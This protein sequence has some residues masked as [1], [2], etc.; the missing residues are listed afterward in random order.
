MGRKVESFL[1]GRF[2]RGGLIDYSGK[3]LSRIKTKMASID[4]SSSTKQHLSPWCDRH[5]PLILLDNV[6]EYDHYSTRE[7]RQPTPNTA[8]QHR[9]Q[10]QATIWP[11][12]Q[13]PRAPPPRKA[14]HLPLSDQT[15]IAFQLDPTK[16]EQLIKLIK[17]DEPLWSF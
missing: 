12:A 17:A 11:C 15:C 10:Y 16:F 4:Q 8:C 7:L 14:G 6:E 2:D 13:H 5:I 1:I 9:N 3:T